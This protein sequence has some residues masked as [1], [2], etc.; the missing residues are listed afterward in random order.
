MVTD[1]I[2]FVYTVGDGVTT[3]FSYAYNGTVGFDADVAEDV[4][5]AILNP[6][7]TRD[8]NPNFAV[9]KD[10]YG[11][12]TG[13]IRFATAPVANAIIYIYR[14]TPQ[15]QETEYKTSS[16]FDAKNVENDF[17]KLTK[18][19]QETSSHARNKTVQLD[20]FQE[21]VLK[22]ILASEANQNQMLFF[23]F[24]TLTF[25]FT[26]FTKGQAVISSAS[27]S[28]DKTDI[29]L[30][31]L[32]DEDTGLP[33]LAFSLDQGATWKPMN[34][35][36]I[37]A[38]VN[39][40][41]AKAQEALDNSETAV[42]VAAAAKAAASATYSKTEVDNALA[43]KLNIQQGAENVGKILKIG[44][45]GNVIASSE[46]AGLA[47]VNHDNTL[48]GAG[49]ETS[50]LTISDKEKLANKIT[51]CILNVPQNI[52]LSLENGVL[53]LK[54]GSTVYVPNGVGVYNKNTLVSDDVFQL[55][56]F[57]QSKGVLVYGLQ[58]DYF[59]FER[60]W[61]GPTE[62]TNL[63]GNTHIWYDTANNVIKY[64]SN[65]GTTWNTY[66]ISLPIAVVSMDS[67]GTITSIDQVFDGFGFIGNTV[68]SLPGLQ[69]AVPNGINE[70]GT[71]NNNVFTTD[72]VF[73]TSTVGNVLNAIGLYTT[74]IGN[75]MGYYVVDVYS[76]MI[77]LNKNGFYY[78]V[79][80]NKIYSWTGNQGIIYDKFV[81]VCYANN[82]SNKITDLKTKYAFRAVDYNEYQ[83][84]INNLESGK[85]DNLTQEQLNAVNSGITAA[86]VSTYDGYAA[87]IAGKQNTLTA[88]ANISISGNTISA[89]GLA[90][91]DLSNI[92]SNIDYVVESQEPTSE[93]GY[94]WYRLYKSGW[95]EQGGRYANKQN[96][97]TTMPVAMS[98]TN[99]SVVLT[100]ETDSG[101]TPTY[102]ALAIAMSKTTTSFTIKNAGS[103]FGGWQ[104]SGMAA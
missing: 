67:S 72:E 34:F 80:E 104:V 52:D 96:I 53:K 30:T 92:S 102:S 84:A 71:L 19:V 55:Q 44:T 5:A 62:P 87:Q 63:T 12:F 15:T 103:I 39:S 100:Y 89:T 41:N 45:D 46:A 24:S 28:D 95:V 98:D 76:D 20:M 10:T 26:S 65:A 88:G 40:A 17:D 86:K 43:K 1:P 42:S 91:T 18:L 32:T 13:A 4:R 7:G 11:N 57:G 48:E 25:R 58:D 90:K 64:T 54:A 70:D 14:A 61:A 29:M 23:D 35:A 82:V 79:S 68:F 56:N 37:S 74:G 66:N 81:I 85:Q 73:T 69:V 78:V 93:N 75:R 60:T 94:T 51:N 3:D 27:A 97:L 83:N 99:Y 16:G 77:N 8:T 101:I 6:D 36:E 9:L 2:K 38:I 50:P 21:N 47:S 33:Y 49:T 22:F 59:P 31:H